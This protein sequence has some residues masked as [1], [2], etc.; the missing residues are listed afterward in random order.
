MKKKYKPLT[1]KQAANLI[2]KFKKYIPEFC[3]VMRIQRDIPTFM[4]EAGVDMTNLR[5]YVH[6]LMKKKKIKCRCIRCREAGRAMVKLG[7]P[8]IKV[9]HYKASQGTEFFI[10]AESKD[11]VLG[12]CRL[13][14]PSQ[15]L[16]KE[17]TQDSA[18]VRELHVYG[19][20]VQIGKKGSVQHKGIGKRLLKEAEKIAKTYNK[21][22][23]VV[24]SGVGARNYYKRLGYRKEGGYVVKKLDMI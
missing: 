12:F 8:K 3:R 23:M 14:F 2:V 9:I 7:K 17:I 18:L 4:T 24:I 19:E 6:E 13:R 11:Y 15:F 5:Q 1:T 22:K 16:R 21:K 10:S 20:A